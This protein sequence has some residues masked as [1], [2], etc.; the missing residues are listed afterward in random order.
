[1]TRASG[2]R[3][4]LRGFL[5]KRQTYN[6]YI[7]DFRRK[8]QENLWSL[9]LESHKKC[10]WTEPLLK[11]KGLPQ[12]RIIIFQCF[13]CSHSCCHWKEIDFKSLNKERGRE[14]EQSVKWMDS[15]VEEIWL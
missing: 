11:Q 6:I 9:I 14:M 15:S 5:N 13:S 12:I 8:S 10:I 2:G 1:M 7:Y 3:G 4:K